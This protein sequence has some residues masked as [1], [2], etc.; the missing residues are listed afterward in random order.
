MQWQLNLAHYLHRYLHRQIDRSKNGS[1]PSAQAPDAWKDQAAFVHTATQ[2]IRSV[3]GVIRTKKDG[4]SFFQDPPIVM[5]EAFMN[6]T[7][8][9]CHACNIAAS[10]TVKI[11]RALGIYQQKLARL[12]GKKP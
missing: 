6:I 12:P 8:P 4:A 5:D 10:H 9:C 11:K 7:S 1:Q 3:Q 2:L